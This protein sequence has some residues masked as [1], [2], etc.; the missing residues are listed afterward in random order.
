[1]G[2]ARRNYTL[3]LTQEQAAVVSRACELYARLGYGQFGEVIWQYMNLTD[4]DFCDRRDE[5]EVY[6][7][8][9][10]ALIYPELGEARG[11]SYGIGRDD[12]LDRSFDVHQVLRHALGDEREPWTNLGELP[13]CRVEEKT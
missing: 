4:E 7:Y 2:K 12:D 8:K 13:G 11:R 9:A 5:A 10:R 1:M 3:E 6:L